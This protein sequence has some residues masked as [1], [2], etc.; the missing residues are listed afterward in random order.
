M[1][2]LLSLRALALN[3]GRDARAPGFKSRIHLHAAIAYRT[4]AH[5]PAR[6]CL[7]S[8]S[9]E[10]AFEDLLA[11]ER[12]LEAVEYE[13]RAEQRGEG[14]ASRV[15]RGEVGGDRVE[16]EEEYEELREEERQHAEA[17]EYEDGYGGGNEAERE[18]YGRLA[19]AEEEGG[20]EQ[21]QQNHRQA[22]APRDYRQQE[23]QEHQHGGEKK[24]VQHLRH[25]E[26]HHVLKPH[27]PLQGYLRG[28]RGRKP[29]PARDENLKV[30]EEHQPAPEERPEQ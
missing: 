13:A 10:R 27:Q 25:E 7:P 30:P 20:A 6:F 23:Q 18:V 9:D 21:A 8:V 16:V 26:V 12:G 5:Y 28:R 15:P 11:R 3:A 19:A 17:H 1:K 24:R 4:P 2:A 29:G 22:L 14:R